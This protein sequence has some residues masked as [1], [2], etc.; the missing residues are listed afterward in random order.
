V[1]SIAPTQ[2]QPAKDLFKKTTN[3]FWLE[4]TKVL[5]IL[6]FLF[7]AKSVQKNTKVQFKTFLILINC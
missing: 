7:Q 4:P 2:C 5:N 3:I 6:S 1:L